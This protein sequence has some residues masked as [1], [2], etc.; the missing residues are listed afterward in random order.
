MSSKSRIPWTAYAYLKGEDHLRTDVITPLGGTIFRIFSKD[1]QITLL[2]PVKKSYCEPPLNSYKFWP[3]GPLFSV[4]DLYH[5]LRDK[6]PEKWS[7]SP[8][9][10]TKSTLCILPEGNF[11]ISLK[12]KRKKKILELKE[13]G[14]L[15]LT[16]TIIPL[17]GKLLEDKVFSFNTQDWTRLT[18]CKEQVL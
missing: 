11:K 6:T 10:E 9:A 1:D 16:L 2:F 8:S 4:T 7:C 3:K 18:D 14:K 17:S 15:H 13:G 5:L 12:Q